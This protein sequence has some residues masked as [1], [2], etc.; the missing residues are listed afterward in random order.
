MAWGQSCNSP[1][2]R[3]MPLACLDGQNLSISVL[4]I[5]RSIVLRYNSH[6]KKSYGSVYSK[7]AIW[8]GSVS[9]FEVFSERPIL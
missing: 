4:E 6:F 3:D 5:C 8:N 1:K 9:T 2:R 7:K